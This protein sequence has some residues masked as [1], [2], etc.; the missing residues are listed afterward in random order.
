[1]DTLLVSTDSAVNVAPASWQ[2]RDSA[3]SGRFSSALL[4]EM[5]Q[6]AD[7]SGSTEAADTHGSKTSLAAAPAKS[8]LSLKQSAGLGDSTSV[9][10]E[11]QSAAEPL[12]EADPN[13]A[14]A[15]G[16]MPLQLPLAETSTRDPD[17]ATHTMTQTDKPPGDTS[18]SA[19]VVAT[20][21]ATTA[22]NSASTAAVLASAASVPGNPRN[23]SSSA[24]AHASTPAA[25]LQG[26]SADPTSSAQLQT[27][28]NQYAQQTSTPLNAASPLAANAAEDGKLLPQGGAALPARTRSKSDN[29]SSATVLASSAHK[30]NPGQLGEFL[31]GLLSGEAVALDKTGST[32]ELIPQTVTAPEL[33]TAKLALTTMPASHARDSSPNSALNPLADTSATARAN[34]PFYLGSQIPAGSAGWGE[35]IGSHINWLS[36]HKIS[37]AEISLHPAE[38]GALDITIKTE[39]DRI[40]VS[41]VTRNEAARELLESSLPKLAELLRNNGLA[42]EQGSVSQQHT[43]HGRD[44]HADSSHSG[45]RQD[46]ASEPQDMQPLRLRTALLHDGQI[47]HY[48]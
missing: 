26:Q 33:D 1:M 23:T 17:N 44:G 47:D 5:A 36:N 38:L 20:M 16:L 8:A 9:G 30:Q 18:V 21:A 31:S 42:L 27:L 14:V 4:K 48:V 24:V 35:E 29:A 34:A 39:D 25:S 15:M 45:L 46:G 2:G 41:I 28:L 12:V 22:E 13:A 40:S 19:T 11:L 10:L 32:L 7:A 37:K 3:N 43:A 6:D